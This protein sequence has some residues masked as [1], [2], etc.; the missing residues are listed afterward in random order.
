MAGRILIADT[1]AANRIIL[2]V[3]LEAAAGT[4]SCRPPAAT[5][6]WTGPGPIIPTW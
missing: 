4:R 6:C 2:K 3:K 1:T 5:R